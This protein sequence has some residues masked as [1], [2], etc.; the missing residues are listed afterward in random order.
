MTDRS[1]RLGCIRYLLSCTK[2]K[3]LLGVKYW[4]LDWML[5]WTL[6]LTR[7]WVGL[8]TRRDISRLRLETYETRRLEMVRQDFYENFSLVVIVQISVRQ[9]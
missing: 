4:M 9:R 8:G 6:N 2:L 7:Y 3:S 5:V 1:L